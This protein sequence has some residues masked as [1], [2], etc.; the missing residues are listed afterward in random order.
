MDG[1]VHG[2]KLQ[3]DCLFILVTLDDWLFFGQDIK[4]DIFLKAKQ[5][6]EKKNVNFD[7]IR[8]RALVLCSAAELEELFSS[9]PE[10]EITRILASNLGD[11]GMKDYPLHSV[12]QEQGAERLPFRAHPLVGR[13]TSFFD[14]F[15]PAEYVF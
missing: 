7:R 5:I 15:P 9:F 11:L 1:G 10:S 8:E 14:Q 13:A 6:C 2:W 4:G 12:I 3:K